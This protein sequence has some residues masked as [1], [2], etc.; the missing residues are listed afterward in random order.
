MQKWMDTRGGSSRY[1]QCQATKKRS[2]GFSSLWSLVLAGGYG[3]RLRQNTE[4]RFGAYRPKQ[5][6]V[7]MGKRS[8]IQHTWI[9][10]KTLCLPH[11]VVTVMDQS[12]WSYVRTQLI[13]ESLGP[14]V[15]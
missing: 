13:Q 11:Q 7:F 3:E 5:Y 2:Q 4:Q 15:W 8:M 12:Y 10:A 9:R 14:V 6:C 1:S